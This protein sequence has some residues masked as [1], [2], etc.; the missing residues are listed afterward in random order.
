M[1]WSRL[2]WVLFIYGHVLSVCVGL[3]N[4]HLNCAVVIQSLIPGACLGPQKSVCGEG[5]CRARFVK[6]HKEDEPIQPPRDFL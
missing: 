3:S 1:L 5:L 6:D 2:R 4:M